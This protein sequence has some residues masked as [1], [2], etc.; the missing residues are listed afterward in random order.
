MTARNPADLFSEALALPASER[1][2]FLDNACGGDAALRA[3]IESLLA[4]LP[5]ARKLFDGAPH[6]AADDGSSP[7]PALGL[8]LGPW[9]LCERIATGGMGAVYRGE[10]VDAAFRKQVAVKIISPWL[11]GA[12]I[13]ERFR[14]ERQVL[15]DLEH[16]HIA[17]LLDGGATP[18]GR[19]Y[20]VMEFVDGE[21]IDRH[22][23]RARLSVAARLRLFLTVCEAVQF[24]H[25]NLVIHRDLKPGNILV[26]REGQVKLLDFG[27]AKVLSGEATTEADAGSGPDLTMPAAMTPRY[28]SP[29]Q[30]LGHRVTTATDVY[31]LGV[32][33]CELLS[34]ASPYEM[35]TL[36]TPA[37]ARVICESEPTRPSRVAARQDAAFAARR[38]HSPA[39]LAQALAGDL[40]NIVL[41]TLRKDPERR[42]ASVD[43][44][45]E[46]IR[47]HLDGL[48]VL[49]APD[50]LS[51]RAGKFL[52]RHRSLTIATTAT[53]ALLATA[54]VVSI[55]ALR[56]AEMQTR[57]AQQL[58]YVNSLAAA[59][60]ALRENAV[61]EAAGR[62]EAAPAALRGWEW[63]H[64][65]AR[66]DRSLVT[67]RAHEQGA[68][69]VRFA[70]DGAAVFTTSLD[71]T[72]RE[73]DAATGAA[74]RT[75]GPLGESVEGVALAPDGAWL[76]AGLNDGRVVIL[77]R[78]AQSAPVVLHEG[79]GWASVAVS[80]DGGRIAAAHRD[81]FVRV[82]D[83]TTHRMVGSWP[84]H[85]DFA[86]VAWAPRGD[87]LVTGGGDGLVKVWEPASG[88]L[89]HTFNRHTR[90]V[91]CLAVSE[92]GRL[93]ASGGMDQLAV[94]H[95]LQTGEHVTTFHAHS[96]TV[97][98]LTFMSGDRQVLSVAPDGR[99][100]R[101]D[102]RTGAV[103]TELRGH[104]RDVNAVTASADGRLLASADWGGV[105]KIW[106]AEVAD[107]AVFRVL[108][109]PTLVVNVGCLAIDPAGRVVIGGNSQGG[110]PVWPLPGSSTLPTRV[111]GTEPATS[112]GFS[113][114]GG[115]LLAGTTT[116]RLLV[117]DATAWTAT[118]TLTAHR[119]EVNGLAVHPTGRWVA[120]GGNDA[121][122]RIW[123]LGADGLLARTPRELGRCGGALKDLV[124][125]P[126]GVL[127]VGAAVDSA[128]YLWDWRRELPP[129]KLMGHTGAV[130]DACLDPTGRRLVSSGADG[131]LRL[132]SLPDGKLLASQSL[133]RGRVG[134]AAWS[135][136]GTRLAVGGIDGVVRLLDAGSLREMVGLRG[137]V[138]RVM[139]LGFAPDDAC[140]VSSS[141]DG[142][143]RA[144]TALG[145]R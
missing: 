40:D 86:Q 81:G 91:Y 11:D 129:R 61:E 141:R 2:A 80:P 17:R 4:A 31:S 74:R 53:V 24:A 104:R 38:E 9:R 134:T 62:L 100:L 95:D 79:S 97:T 42:Y 143:M 29:E 34:G 106:A 114:D 73:W 121:R 87:R 140:L 113:P 85:A 36:M 16:P 12:D 54:L 83:A 69:C 35:P 99:L 71:G 82:W 131:T 120:T 122:V 132:W 76:V 107:V 14:R 41:K 98:N 102:V 96:A 48:P 89:L 22:A 116:G 139:A 65:E 20:L 30:V 78:A 27:I 84:A 111:D 118:D 110:L 136:D 115:R 130:L 109:L 93:V 63:R 44:L 19:P 21:P 28:A 112:L 142:T 6:L 18:D 70:P 52:R 68:T 51:Y 90:R 144:W 105:L 57:E 75:W 92:D 45:A 55:G 66:L 77:D 56:R 7:D 94:V 50:R 43:E 145:A 8:A 138:A 127:L 39:R 58:A 133:G 137:H 108:S 88:R 49:A 47:R 26:D 59:E 124:F 5:A 15:A 128:V 32:L 10:R 72:V 3:E 101:W 37:A 135:R 117:L 46:D 103:L 64:L 125:T 67:V 126:D 119:G 1:A 25:R 60:S 123:E 23:D 33:L 13:V